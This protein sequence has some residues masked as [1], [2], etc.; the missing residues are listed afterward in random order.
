MLAFDDTC[1]CFQVTGLIGSA[2]LANRVILLKLKFGL[3]PGDSQG[4]PK[5][6]LKT[7][8]VR[9][10]FTSDQRVWDWFTTTPE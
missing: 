9:S 10:S 6:C 5:M 8:V 3:L 7:V 1:F 2:Q 4:K